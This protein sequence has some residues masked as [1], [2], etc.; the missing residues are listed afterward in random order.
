MTPA[1]YV[2][3]VALIIQQWDPWSYE[4]SILQCRG[5]LGWQEGNAWVDEGAP[6]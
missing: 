2:A 3:E 4:D 5:M 1:A 6:S